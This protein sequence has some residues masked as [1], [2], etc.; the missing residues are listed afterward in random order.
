[1]KSQIVVKYE[2]WRED[3]GGID[4]RHMGALEER[5]EDVIFEEMAA[6]RRSGVLE[7]NIYMLDSDPEDGVAYSGS[8]EIVR[9]GDIECRS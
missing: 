8:W 3:Q 1:M 5:A 6:G 7:D 4:P 9:R 2:W